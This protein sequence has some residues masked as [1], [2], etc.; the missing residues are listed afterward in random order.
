M[1]ALCRDFCAAA[2]SLRFDTVLALVLVDGAVAHTAMHER[3]TG[4][5]EMDTALCWTSVCQL[6]ASSE[7]EDDDALAAMPAAMADATASALTYADAVA[8][9][10]DTEDQ[11]DDL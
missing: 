11:D 9:E 5:L 7:S 1:G 8:A 3:L 6:L 4:V 2:C 10:E